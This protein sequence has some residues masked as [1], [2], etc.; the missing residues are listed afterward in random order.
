MVLTVRG[1][2]RG[3]A[4]GLALGAAWGAAA[5]GWMRLVSTEPEFSWEG[6]LAIVGFATLLGL[7]V[8]LVT[9]ALRQGRSG[10]WRL[11]VVPGLILF[12]SPGIVM[13]PG[14]VI[15]GI[16]A[17][18]RTRRGW[19]V[20]AGG[21]AVV[22]LVMSLAA[23]SSDPLS[24]RLWL[25]AGMTLLTLAIAWGWRDLFTTAPG[26]AN[27]ARPDG[28]AAFAEGADPAQLTASSASTTPSPK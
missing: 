5:R 23:A 12:L 15:G 7:L 10:W 18:R 19:L 14:C 27:A 4:L 1:L 3:A 22:P 11:A 28:R 20:A 24:V 13:L 6:T 21:A 26:R 8:G 17:A 9:I 2:L 16:A 25:L